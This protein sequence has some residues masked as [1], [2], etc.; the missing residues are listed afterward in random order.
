[1]WQFSPAM[2]VDVIGVR[3][4]LPC[5]RF[6]AVDHPRAW[7]GSRGPHTCARRWSTPLVAMACVGT[8][9]SPVSFDVCR[10]EILY[11]TIRYD[12]I[13][14]FNVCCVTDSFNVGLCIMYRF[15]GRTSASVGQ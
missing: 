14:E 2:I 12:T 9:I 1:M 3:P 8:P 4:P 15:N 7:R 6:M 11:D 10:C 5:M 13:E